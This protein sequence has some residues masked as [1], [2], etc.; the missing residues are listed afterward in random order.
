VQMSIVIV[1]REKII[2]CKMSEAKRESLHPATLPG[3]LHTDLP[4][5][6]SGGIGG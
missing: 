6:L 1:R 5:G 4:I 2:I 3:R